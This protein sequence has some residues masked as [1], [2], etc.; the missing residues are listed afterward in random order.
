[1]VGK[2]VD[3]L[4]VGGGITTHTAAIYSSRASLNTLILSAL[5]LDQLSLTTLV[6]NFPGFPEGVMG[7]KLI[8]DSKAQAQKFGAKYEMGKVNA[9][10]KIKDGFEVSTEDKKKYQSKTVI[11]ATGASAITLDVPGKDKYFGKGISVCAVCDAALFRGKETTVI[12]GG[13]AAMEDALALTKFA[14]KVTIVHRRKEFRASKIMINRV[15]K[16]KKIKVVWDSTLQE[17]LGDGKFVTGIKVKNVNTGKVQEI[18][19]QGMFFAIGHKPNTDFL[20]KFVKLDKRGFIETNNKRETSVPG[21]YAAGDVQDP[22]FKQAIT[23]AGAGCEASLSAEKYV[24][25]FEGNN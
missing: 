12:G 9:I 23:S 2:M 25:H 11:L 21:V 18:K 3:V 4:I 10:K 16:N 8:Q 17:V 22:I 13:D 6:E 19:C 5:E 20:K 15:L 7:P 1:M 14:T 24:E